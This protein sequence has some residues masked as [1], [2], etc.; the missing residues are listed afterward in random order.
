MTSRTIPTKI[1][2]V[3][4]LALALAAPA[5]SARG[6][7]ESAATGA[8]AKQDLRSPDARDAAT[9]A[10]SPAATAPKQD[11]RSPDARD[12]ARPNPTAV[13]PGQPT[14]PVNPKPIT[15]VTVTAPDGGGGIGTAPLLGLI[16][17]G[18]V[19]IGGAGAVAIRSR[20]PRTSL[21]G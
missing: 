15:P 1:A 14:W 2:A 20:R 11:L 4:A 7:D 13:A 16:T 18:I 10:Q 9:R 6:A 12:A 19:L 8:Q 17:G 5:A 21:T 3:A